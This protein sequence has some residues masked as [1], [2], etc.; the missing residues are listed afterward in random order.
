M[1]ESTGQRK[2]NRALEEMNQFLLQRDL[3]G[4][5]HLADSLDQHLDQTA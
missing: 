1:N 4:A 5:A 2:A 3:V